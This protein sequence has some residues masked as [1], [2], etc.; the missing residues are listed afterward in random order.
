MWRTTTGALLRARILALGEELGLPL[1]VRGSELIA[2]VETSQSAGIFVPDLVES[3]RDR[4]VLLSNTGPLGNVLK[5]RSP[6]VWNGRHVEVFIDALH[7]SLV[8]QG[9]RTS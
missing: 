2:G 1:T 9:R 6:L 8:E 7:N 5:V 4:Q 3:L